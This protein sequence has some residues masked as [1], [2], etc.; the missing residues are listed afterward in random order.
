MVCQLRNAKLNQ[1]LKISANMKTENK[2]RIYRMGFLAGLYDYHAQRMLN[3]ESLRD[4]SDYATNEAAAGMINFFFGTEI[5]PANLYRDNSET[6][7]KCIELKEKF[8]E[9]LENVTDLEIMTKDQISS[10]IKHLDTTPE[11]FM[12]RFKNVIWAPFMTQA[13]GYA[14]GVISE[15]KFIKVLDYYQSKEFPLNFEL[16][17]MISCMQR[18]EVVLE[19]LSVST[20]GKNQCSNRKL[21]TVKNSK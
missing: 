18:I 5:S 7:N 12:M 8:D 4:P 21:I 20:S 6:A 2:V 11:L 13:I 1:Q 3:E 15:R 10:A 16:K 9:L 14:S 17:I 19:M